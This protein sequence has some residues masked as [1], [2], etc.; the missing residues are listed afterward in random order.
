MI[1]ADLHEGNL[2]VTD[3]GMVVID[4]D[5]AG[6]GWHVY[7]LAVA[8]FS[9]CDR[10]DFTNIQDALI[11]GYKSLRDLADEDLAILPL[12]IL[13][14]TLALLGWASSRPE[15]G[16]EDYVRYLT[17]KACSTRV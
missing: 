14:R 10:P 11:N 16:I 2:F 15:L 17:D 5:D 13:V 12:F 9:F 7:D 6:F 3:A 4:F 1:H 8:L